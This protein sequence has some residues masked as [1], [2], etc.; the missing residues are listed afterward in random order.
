MK[1]TTIYVLLLL[2][3]FFSAQIC[4]ASE[5]IETSKKLTIDDVEQALKL[6]K[7]NSVISGFSGMN[8]SDLEDT[9]IDGIYQSDGVA[10]IYFDGIIPAK[11]KYNAGKQVLGK[12]ILI[13]LNSGKWYDP[14]K[15]VFLR[16]GYTNN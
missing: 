1:N 16:K 10:T 7:I 4:L 15:H 5:V 2:M 6:N 14:S 3:A 8:F 11:I 13:R 12:V 9:H